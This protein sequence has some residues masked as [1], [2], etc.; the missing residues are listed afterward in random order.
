[1]TATREKKNKYKREWYIKNKDK[2]RAANQRYWQKK[3]AALA[4]EQKGEADDE[5]KG[6]Q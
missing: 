2:V 5:R 3:L 4:A 6:D 1:M